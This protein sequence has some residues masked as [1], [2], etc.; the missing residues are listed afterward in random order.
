MVDASSTSTLPVHL[1][2][3]FLHL[4]TIS[5]LC[6]FF[7]SII[8]LTPSSSP[9][10]SLALP[11]SG[12]LPVSSLLAPSMFG[13]APPQTQCVVAAEDSG[14]RYSSG[15][16]SQSPLTVEIYLPPVRG[17]PQQGPLHQPAHH[18]ISEE[19][20][21]FLEIHPVGMTGNKLWVQFIQTAAAFILVTTQTNK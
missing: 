14:W 11:K 19:V 21:E 18:H 6:C 7:S 20:T 9:S 13:A 5:S 1:H 17:G 12:L 3:P 8:S 16:G 2:L 15:G 10:W 4:S